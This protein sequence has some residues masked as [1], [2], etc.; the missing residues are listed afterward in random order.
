MNLENHYPKLNTKVKPT[1]KCMKE[2]G[3]GPLLTLEWVE[4]NRYEKMTKHS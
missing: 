2:K 4:K 1:R 3:G